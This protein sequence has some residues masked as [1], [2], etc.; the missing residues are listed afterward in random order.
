MIRLRY[1]RAVTDSLIACFKLSKDD[2]N[3]WV[4]QRFD[5]RSK[6]YKCYN[7][8]EPDLTLNVNQERLVY[9]VEA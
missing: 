5:H 7:L 3:I 1:L 6:H 8:D 2:P 4:I 9:E